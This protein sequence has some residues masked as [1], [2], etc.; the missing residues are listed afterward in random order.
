M[1]TASAFP[2]LLTAPATLLLHSSN[3]RTATVAFLAKRFRR[4]PLEC[5]VRDGSSYKLLY[6]P[7]H[8]L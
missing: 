4:F 3:A 1:K 6:L 7:E 5:A 2:F 8:A